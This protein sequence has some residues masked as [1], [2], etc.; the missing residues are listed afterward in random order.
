M[1]SGISDLIPIQF[2]ASSGLSA[3]QF[4]F[5]HDG[6]TFPSWHEENYPI[7][8]M[9][10]EKWQNVFVPIT[11]FPRESEALSILGT[12][13]GESER[14]GRYINVH[15]AYEAV[16]TDRDVTLSAI[17]HALAHPITSLTRPAVRAALEQH[18]GGNRIN[19]NTYDHKKIYFKCLAQMLISIDETLFKTFSLRWSELLVE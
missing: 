16:V 9:R 14:E 18:F 10:D 15:S 4:R 8:I 11:L 1:H 19:L 3:H 2:R 7:F 13:T 6:Y 12:L 5:R 17:R